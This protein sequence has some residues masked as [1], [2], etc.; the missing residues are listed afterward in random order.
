M[1]DTPQGE[2]LTEA[3]TRFNGYKCVQDTI[4][5]NNIDCTAPA[6]AS[7]TAHTD[8]QSLG[9]Q[10]CIVY[11]NFPASKYA[12][13]YN[14]QNPPFCTGSGATGFTGPQM[15]SYMVKTLNSAQ[16]FKTSMTNLKIK[17][18]DFYVPEKTVF[19]KIK[20]SITNIENIQAKIITATSLL[21]DVQK[22]VKSIA[23]CKIINKELILLENVVCFRV[24][25][26][27]YVQ[28]VY[29]VIVGTLLFVYSWFICCSIRLSNKKDKTTAAPVN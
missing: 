14:T 16:A 22:T 25:N 13:R 19:D 6:I 20:A 18:D 9:S 7:T 12:N 17:F 24:G 5:F 8:T 27:F 23:N 1:R 29:G 2:D 26:D 3:K 4:Q 21:S 10:Y 11:N 28:V 15:N